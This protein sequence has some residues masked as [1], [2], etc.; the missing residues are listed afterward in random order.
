MMEMAQDQSVTSLTLFA[1][2]RDFF[3]AVEFAVNKGK[4]TNIVAFRDNFAPRLSHL[5]DHSNIA[6][7]N[8]YWPT[9][10]ELQGAGSLLP[11]DFDYKLKEA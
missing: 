1:G 11:P 4:I 9:M 3:D 10:C 6:F 8:D 5:L 2:D 7:L